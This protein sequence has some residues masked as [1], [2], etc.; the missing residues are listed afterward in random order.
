ME[1]REEGVG[2]KWNNGKEGGRG[3]VRVESWKER[4]EEGMGLEWNHG[5]KGGARRMRVDSWIEGKGRGEEG[6]ARV[7]SCKEVKGVRVESWKEREK[8]VSVKS[9]KDGMDGGGR[10]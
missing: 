5:R 7:Q 1:R 2:L 9:W 4:R 8:G 3:G 6:G 10:G